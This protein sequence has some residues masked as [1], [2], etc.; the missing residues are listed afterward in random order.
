[1]GD[2]VFCLEVAVDDLVLV[3]LH[4]SVDDVLADDHCLVLGNGRLLVDFFL[5]ILTIAVLD[6]HYLEVLVA[7]HVVELDEV[8]AIAHV[9]QPGLCLS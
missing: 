3:H 2:Y 1:M 7:V 4:Q 5:Q 9:H 6:H 8:G